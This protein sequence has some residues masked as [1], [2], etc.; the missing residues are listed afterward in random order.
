MVGSFV[1]SCG[2]CWSSKVGIKIESAGWCH[3]LIHMFMCKRENTKMHVFRW[4]WL[5]MK[6][7]LHHDIAQNEIG[8]DWIRLA[9]T[10][11]LFSNTS[12]PN[13][14]ESCVNHVLSWELNR[15]D[16]LV[17]G[18]FTPDTSLVKW[19]MAAR[20]AWWSSGCDIAGEKSTSGSTFM[21]F[22]LILLPKKTWGNWTT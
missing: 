7:H 4:I 13:Q 16:V 12:S 5:Q 6:R 17:L 22:G 18:L 15:P 3:R 19:R 21:W 20:V 9:A 10:R 8:V 14:S 1:A 11:S 2:S